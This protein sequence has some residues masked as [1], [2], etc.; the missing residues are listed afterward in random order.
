M[1]QWDQEWSPSILNTSWYTDELREEKHKRRKLE[2]KWKRTRSEADEVAHKKHCRS[3]T[4]IVGEA[5]TAHYSTKLIEAK[6]NQK[7]V[8]SIINSQLHRKNKQVLP[9]N[10]NLEDLCEES[11][12]FF[13]EKIIKIRLDL[14]NEAA[15]NH[16]SATKTSDSHNP[17]IN[18]ELNRFHTV[19]N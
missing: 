9:D 14:E 19:R 1:H 4:K 12:D 11:A 2:R 18:Q 8:F 17:T 13:A 16:T 10:N 7:E 3:L 15:E 6:G 5:K